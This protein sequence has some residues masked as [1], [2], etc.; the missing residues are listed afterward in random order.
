PPFVAA[1]TATALV[2]SGT[3]FKSFTVTPDVQ[4]AVNLCAADHGWLIRDQNETA[5]NDQVNYVALEDKHPAQLAKRP[6]LTVDFTPPP[7]STDA[8]CAD[9]NACTMNERCVSGVC[10]VDP[11]NCDD[12]DPCTDDICDCA[13][14]CI[15][16]NICND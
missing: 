6:K 2:G 14:G 4:T 13:T 7:C 10:V 5:S 15:N 12:G 9:T 8:D 11:V 3:G 1:P 16:S